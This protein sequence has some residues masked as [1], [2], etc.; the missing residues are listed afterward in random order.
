MKLQFSDTPNCSVVVPGQGNAA[1]CAG[2]TDQGAPY[3]W[4]VLSLYLSPSPS[5][6]LPP[7]LLIYVY[8]SSYIYIL[9]RFARSEVAGD[10]VVANKYF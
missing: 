7:S 9:N 3:V 4:L 5:P 2:A 8:V 6:S 10:K 1:C